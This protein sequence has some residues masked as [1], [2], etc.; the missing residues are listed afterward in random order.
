M[1]LGLEGSISLENS[2]KSNGPIILE[3]SNDQKTPSKKSVSLYLQIV[4]D[5]NLDL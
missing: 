2:T 1:S 4:E 3:D 5:F